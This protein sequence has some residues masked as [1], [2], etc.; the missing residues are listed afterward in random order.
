MRTSRSP[1]PHILP[2][3]MAKGGGGGAGGG[4]WGV[5]LMLQVSTTYYVLQSVS[6]VAI[7]HIMRVADASLHCLSTPSIPAQPSECIQQH[8]QWL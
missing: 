7:T 6:L 8:H 1:L 5:Q 4:G 2:G 3:N